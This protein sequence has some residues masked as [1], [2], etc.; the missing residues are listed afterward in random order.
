MRLVRPALALSL[1]AAACGPADDFDE[2]PATFDAESGGALTATLG[3]VRFDLSAAKASGGRLVFAG[4]SNARFTSALAFVPDDAVGTTTN[5]ATKVKATFA[6]AEIQPLVEGL[7]LFVSLSLKLGAATRT[8]V[9]KADLRAAIVRTSGATGIEPRAWFQAFRVGDETVV[10]VRGRAPG[11]VGAITGKLGAT[12]ITGTFE[13]REWVLDVPAAA[14]LET[15]AA[16]RTLS[17]SLKVDGRTLRAGFRP[18]VIVGRLALAE[19]DAYELWPA[20]TCTDELRACVAGA[21]EDTSACGDAY[22]V[23]R[24]PKSNG[25]GPWTVDDARGWVVAAMENLA[26]D[27]GGYYERILGESRGEAMSGAVSDRSAAVA[28]TLV[29]LSFETPEAALARARVASIPVFEEAIAH[30]FRFVAPSAPVAGDPNA[31]RDTAVAAIVRHLEGMDLE[32]SEY[33][34][35]FDKLVRRYHGQWVAS[36]EHLRMGGGES[37][38]VEQPDAFVVTGRVLGSYVEIT[39]SRATGEATNV[40]F[41]ID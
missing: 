40:L 36:L 39:V 22:T 12:T 21:G 18:Q 23:R 25:I 20:A 3:D 37:E 7:P 14:F 1:L 33:A 38:L 10:R 35:S 24:C 17:L 8:L 27:Y 19:G 30:P 15:A 16:S 13:G 41:E 31:A 11:A 2:E 32:Q 4:T 29:G 9:A 28:A 6:P 34:Q 5:T 26:P